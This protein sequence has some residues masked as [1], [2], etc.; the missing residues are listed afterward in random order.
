MSKPRMARTV[1]RNRQY[2]WR[3][4]G[5]PMDAEPER[6]FSVTT[7]LKGSLPNPALIGWGMKSVAEYAA[8]NHRQV[9][10]MLKTVRLRK[11]PEGRYIGV[12]TDPAS[13]RGRV[14]LDLARKGLLDAI[15]YHGDGGPEALA[16]LDAAPA[17]R[18]SVVRVASATDLDGVDRLLE[19]GEPRVLVDAKVAG[20]AG[21]TGTGVPRELIA[22][23]ASRGALWLAGGLGA[24]NVGGIM[25]AYRPE[26][27]DASSRLESEKGRKDH[28]ALQAFFKEIDNHA[29]Q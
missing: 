25:D 24:D 15:Q 1:G 10:A 17:G 6:F 21:G 13:D 16:A 3:R 22:S 2:E 23:I 18:Y 5:L 12:I 28:R 20:T 11:D 26:L 9:S 19:A 27:I 7:I 14:A 29:R 8:A 4:A